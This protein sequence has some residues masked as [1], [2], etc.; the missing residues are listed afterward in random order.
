[1]PEWAFVNY[2]AE[3][4]FKEV[5]DKAFPGYVKK[6]AKR[7]FGPFLKALLALHEADS[8]ENERFFP[9]FDEAE[10]NYPPAVF[11]WNAANDWEAV[12]DD[13]YRYYAEGEEAPYVGLLRM[14]ITAEGISESMVSIRHTG[15]VLQALDA[16]VCELKELEGYVWR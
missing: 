3:K 15:R 8:A 16:A 7:P 12:F 6:L 2:S 1:M 5:S 10:C 4:K 11:G 9:A 14:P 13:H